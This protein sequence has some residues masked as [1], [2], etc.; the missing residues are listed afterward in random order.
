MKITYMILYFLSGILFL[1]ALLGSSVTKPM[2]DSISEKTIELSGFR[3][4]YLQSV[5]NRIDE[6]IYK[7]KQIEL[8]IEKLKNFF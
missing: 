2:F 4:S 8:Q 6:L 7:S 5:D 1:M 3:K